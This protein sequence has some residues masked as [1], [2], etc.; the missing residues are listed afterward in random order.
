MGGYQSFGIQRKYVEKG[1]GELETAK[2]YDHCIY[3]PNA[4]EKT[5]KYILGLTAG[6]MTTL[7][8]LAALIICLAAFI[9]FISFHH[10]I[11][12]QTSWLVVGIVTLISIFFIQKFRSY[13]TWHDREINHLEE[14]LI[15]KELEKLLGRK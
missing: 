13:L 15:G 1:R 8:S 6:Y 12:T 10:E 9:I 2:A 4:N 3:G 14:E 5:V 11:L 7:S